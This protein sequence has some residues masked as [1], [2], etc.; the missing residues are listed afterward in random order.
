MTMKRPPAKLPTANRI[1]QLEKYKEMISDAERNKA[2]NSIKAQ[3][4]KARLELLQVDKV[5]DKANKRTAADRKRKADKRMQAD[6][7][8]LERIKSQK[9]ECES[10]RR[11]RNRIPKA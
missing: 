9:R 7:A 6:D 1:V 2:A 5:K 3:L 11:A 4:A 10:S 8:E